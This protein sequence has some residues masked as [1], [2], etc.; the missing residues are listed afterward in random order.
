MKTNATLSS[1]GGPVGSVTATCG[2]AEDV[3]GNANGAAVTYDV[4]YRWT[5]FFQP[6]DNGAVNK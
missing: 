3:A 1:S 5:G 6:I 4:D 2:G